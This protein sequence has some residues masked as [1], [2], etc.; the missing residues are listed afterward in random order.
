MKT[1]TFDCTNEACKHE[2]DE[3]FGHLEAHPDE[4]PCP[5]CGKPA[6]KRKVYANPGVRLP[7]GVATYNRGF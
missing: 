5:K 1:F 3:M 7:N 2:F 6:S 4:L